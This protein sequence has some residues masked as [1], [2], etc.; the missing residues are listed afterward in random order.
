LRRGKARVDSDEV[1][2]MADKQADEHVTTVAD[3]WR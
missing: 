3:F 1:L 2:A